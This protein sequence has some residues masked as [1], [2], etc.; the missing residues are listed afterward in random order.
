MAQARIERVSPAGALHTARSVSRAHAPDSNERR[1]AMDTQFAVHWH[2]T[3]AH[4]IAPFS[5]QS[6]D[7]EIS[8][9]WALGV[10]L[11]AARRSYSHRRITPR[12]CRIN[13]RQTSIAN[14]Q[15][16]CRGGSEASQMYSSHID[17]K[18]FYEL[19]L[20][21]FSEAVHTGVGAV[22][23]ASNKIEQMQACQN[24]KIINGLLKDSGEL[25]LCFNLRVA[26]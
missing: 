11:E 7:F 19:Y 20:L 16:H 5:L 21:P 9:E 24:S 17:D 26:R 25:G 1:V 12:H 3:Q 14:G 13:A 18:T 4:T 6:G 23:C 10:E 22:M 8:L 15:E 2:R